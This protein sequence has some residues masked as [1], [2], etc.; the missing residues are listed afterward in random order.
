MPWKT[1]K[2]MDQKVHLIANWQTQNFSK[3]DLSKKYNISRKTV[4]KWI[5]R[6]NQQGIDGLKDQS[7]APIKRPKSTA[8][9][10]VRRIV[11]FKL[12]HPKRGPKKIYHQLTKKHP[13]VNWPQPSTIGYW[14]K[15][16]GLVNP[17]KRRKLV[18][19]YTEPFINCVQE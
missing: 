16:H 3:T 13:K 11:D 8:K 10:L 6:Y 1:I 7:R 2:P 9:H 15:Q 5:H 19:P 12:E 4:N 18:A 14:L 17:R